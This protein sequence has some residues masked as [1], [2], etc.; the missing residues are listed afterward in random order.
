MTFHNYFIHAALVCGMLT[1]YAGRAS[2]A[3]TPAGTVITARATAVYKME[4]SPGFDS[5]HSNTV[6]MS[7]GQS[8]AVNV[9]PASSVVTT[10]GDDTNA[11]FSVIVQNTGNGDDRFSLTIASRKGWAGA[12]YFDGNGDGILQS[13]EL[14]AGPIVQTP[15][16]P[17]DEQYRLLLRIAVPKDRL[18]NGTVD[19]AL[20]TA[21]SLFAP[22]VTASGE[23]RTRVTSATMTGVLAADNPAPNPGDD[24]TFTCTLTN[25]GSLAASDVV[26]SGFVTSGFTFISATGGIVN[27]SLN[28]VT[29]TV[30]AIAPG[31][32]ATVTF[33]LRVNAGTQG[34]TLQEQLSI[35]YT[36]GGS[37]IAMLTNTVLVTVGRVTAGGVR[38]SAA[39]AASV[40]E[41]A[42]TLAYAYNVFNTGTVK[43]AV[44][45][46]CSST[47]K[48]DTRLYTDGNRN[49][50]WDPSDRYLTGSAA[51][52]GV[53]LDS[54]AG[55][56]TVRV[57]A[58][59]FVPWV[60]DQTVDSLAVFIRASGSGVMTDRATVFTTVNAP[61][62]DMTVT[63]SAPPW[64]VGSEVTYTV[65]YR[66]NGSAAIDNVMFV[67]SAPAFTEF[68]AG[69]FSIQG[70]GG[71]SD[72][73]GRLTLS[74]N[75]GNATVA[76][77]MIGRLNAKSSRVF[78]F[79]VK[80]K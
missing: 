76:T 24:V 58:R 55:G 29:W 30:G 25:G 36:S 56:D 70:V 59:A 12:M 66:N 64:T 49:G 23:Y 50:V 80:I 20:V 69:G 45:I 74:T 63:P 4:S 38:I 39:S 10:A 2:A 78:E 60:K 15:N 57:F 77:A 17:A 11:D 40:R 46:G 73:D 52:S 35:A 34:T 9:T 3:G 32:S 6:S 53:A 42:D 13:E 41:P 65:T 7:V 47:Q 44:F 61:D 72:G 31:A 5:S 67:N 18:L 8:A 71:L 48:L 19:T 1:M 26:V 21:R 68:V 54:L 14:A 79:K 62:I 27:S 28:P 43:R 37:S 75:A 51:G 22:H 33:M 16:I